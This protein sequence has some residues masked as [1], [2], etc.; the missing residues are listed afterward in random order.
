M[1]AEERFKWLLANTLERV[2]VLEAQL[3]E[4]RARIVSLEGKA[5]Q[6]DDLLTAPADRMEQR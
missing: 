6:G 1:T 4:A 5:V 2:C 3:E